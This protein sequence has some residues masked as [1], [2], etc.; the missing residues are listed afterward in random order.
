MGKNSVSASLG[1]A[2]PASPNAGSGD[3]APTDYETKDHMDTLMKAHEIMNN[4]T[5]LKAVHALAGRHQG[6]IKSIQDI[7]N[8][9]QNKFGPKKPSVGALKNDNQ[10]EDETADQQNNSY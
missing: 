3:E 9:S 6:A 2:M 10:N 4:P 8:Y 5:K 1:Q 7:K